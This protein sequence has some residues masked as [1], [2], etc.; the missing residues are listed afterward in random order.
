MTLKI[1]IVLYLTFNIL[2]YSPLDSATLSCS[3][4]VTLTWPIQLR[5]YNSLHYRRWDLDLECDRDRDRR[6]RRVCRRSVE[7]RLE[8]LQ[9]RLRRLLRR[10][11]LLF[12][13]SSVAD[14]GLSEELLSPES[15]LAFT[16]RIISFNSSSLVKRAS[17]ARILRSI[18]A[19][20]SALSEKTHT[21][22]WHIVGGVLWKI[23]NLKKYLSFLERSK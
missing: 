7:E 11:L 8:E 10:C 3:S 13:G 4:E 15:R 16:F 9:L 17:S 21:L 18:S 19:L 2:A 22:S 14:S 20:L 1:R 6:R 12:L 5:K 23:S